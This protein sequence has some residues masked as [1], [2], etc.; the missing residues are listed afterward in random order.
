[1]THA[2]CKFLSN[3]VAVISFEDRAGLFPDPNCLLRLN[4]MIERRPMAPASAISTIDEA[5]LLLYQA[6][7]PT[8]QTLFRTLAALVD[9]VPASSTANDRTF[10]FGGRISTCRRMRLVP[11]KNRANH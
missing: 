5:A 1:M 7:D 9:C 3:A 10:S 8:H 4:E 6:F 2:D 11:E